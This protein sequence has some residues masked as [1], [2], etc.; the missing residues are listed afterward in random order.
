MNLAQI[1]NGEPVAITG[2]DVTLPSGASISVE[3][4][5]LWTEAERNA[6]GFYTINEAPPAPE[7]QITVSTELQLIEGV[8]HR[9]AT[10]EPVPLAQIE[11]Q[12]LRAIDAERDA[13]QQEDFLYDFGDT[14]AFDDERTAM[15]PGHGQEIAAGIR[16]LQMKPEDQDNWTRLHGLALGV[17]E[18]SRGGVV[19]PMRAEDNWNIQTT[20][21][22]VVA[23]YAAGVMRG[24]EILFFAGALKSQVR[25]HIAAGDVAAAL[26]VRQN[27][28]WPA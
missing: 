6:E 7:G 19:M 20:A 14:L 26:A 22:D 2:Q 4:L 11:A 9:V 21:A 13:R 24:S 25:A 12:E 15:G 18:A 5:R 8:V 27:A 1:I 17:P 23:V 10:Y 16:A 3:S 28:V